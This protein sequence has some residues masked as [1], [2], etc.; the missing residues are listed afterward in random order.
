M[1]ISNVVTVI[2]PLG[3]KP[4]LCTNKWGLATKVLIAV[5]PKRAKTTG[6]LDKQADILSL[7]AFGL[8]RA[9]GV[10]YEYARPEYNQK[11]I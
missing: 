3:H 6:S 10:A 8:T 11:L 7:S 9:Q 2:H 1:A 4:R 5:L